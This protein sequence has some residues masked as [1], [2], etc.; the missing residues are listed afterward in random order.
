[1]KEVMDIRKSFLKGGVQ[2]QDIE[3]TLQLP[4]NKVC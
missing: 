1:M 3:E 4:T 2:M